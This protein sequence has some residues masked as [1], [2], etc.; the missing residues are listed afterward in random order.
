MMMNLSKN[1]INGDIN[2]INIV[3]AICV[4]WIYLRHSENHYGLQL[5]Q[6]DDFYLTI[7]VNA[8]FLISGYLLFWKQLS[9]PK[10]QESTSEYVCGGVNCCSLI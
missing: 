10:I 3:K 5:G 6:F 9:E 4:I 8:F 2:W 7:Y 1:N